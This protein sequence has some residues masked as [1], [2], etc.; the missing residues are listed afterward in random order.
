MVFVGC[1]LCFLLFL[2]GVSAISTDAE[3]DVYHM[4][5]SGFSWGY[6]MMVSSKSSID[7]LQISASIDQGNLTLTLQTKGDINTSENVGYHLYYNTSEAFYYMYYVNGDGIAIGTFQSETPQIVWAEV[8]A[9]QNMLTTAIEY[10]GSSPV[11]DFYAFAIQ[12]SVSPSEYLLSSEQWWGDWCPDTH[13][14]YLED[15]S[16]NSTQ[17]PESDDDDDDTTPSISPP[18]QPPDTPT[19]GFESILFILSII[20][21]YIWLQKRKP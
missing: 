14:F 13:Y 10:I 21:I 20:L 16:T 12:T 3:D 7:I 6:D 5:R 15:N 2:H 18:A 9:S 19:P 8:T 11:E 1:F 17:P 4:V